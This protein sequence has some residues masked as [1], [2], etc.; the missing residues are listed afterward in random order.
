MHGPSLL[1]TMKETGAMVNLG[2]EDQAGEACAGVQP[3]EMDKNRNLVAEYLA[4]LAASIR[5]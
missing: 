1:D 3:A 5:V 2:L 4:N